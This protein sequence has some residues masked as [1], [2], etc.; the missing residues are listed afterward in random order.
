MVVC[1]DLPRQNCQN[2]T[3][4][5]PRHPRFNPN[6]TRAIQNAMIDKSEFVDQ[7]HNMCRLGVTDEERAEHF[8]VC[9]RTIYRW[10][11]THEAFAEAN[12]GTVAAPFLPQTPV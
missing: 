5:C 12:L 2:P 4:I 11:N 7:V 9:V 3:D 8:E 6:P 1:Y 10:R